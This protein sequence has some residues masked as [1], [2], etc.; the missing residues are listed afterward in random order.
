MKTMKQGFSL[1]ELLVVVAII[2][3]L[4][5]VGTVGYQNYIDGSKERVAVSNAETIARALKSADLAES[6]GVGQTNGCT[7]TVQACVEAI[8]SENGISN[9]YET[10][11]NIA[12]SS[13]CTAESHRGNID[14][15]YDS[16]TGTATITPCIGEVGSVRTSNGITEVLDNFTS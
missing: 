15:D 6:A 4:A 2:G 12:V 13:T 3:I 11:T 14:V 10:G 9:A 16:S 5:A 8:I 1:I 7:G